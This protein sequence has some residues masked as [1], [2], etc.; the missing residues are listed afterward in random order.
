M[1]DRR[2]VSESQQQRWCTQLT[3]SCSHQLFYG[4]IFN[5]FMRVHVLIELDLGKRLIFTHVEG[6]QKVALSH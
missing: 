5:L 4:K 1:W 6:G 3:H 2:V